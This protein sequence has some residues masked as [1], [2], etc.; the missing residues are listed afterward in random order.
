VVAETPIGKLGLSTC[1]DLRFPEMYS[2]LVRAGA[3]VLAV[4]A[5]FTVPTGSYAIAASM[6]DAECDSFTI[7]M[8]AART[9]RYC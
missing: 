3:S 4:P 1:Y 9:G 5:A 7:L 8:Q 6:L 2:A